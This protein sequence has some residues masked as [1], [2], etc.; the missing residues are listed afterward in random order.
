MNDQDVR[1]LLLYTAELWPHYDLPTTPER[2]QLRVDV[3]LEHLS[4]LPFDPV[5]ATL[6]SC[7]GEQFPPTVGALRA[8]ALELTGARL[9]PEPDQAVAEIFSAVARVGYHTPPEWSHPAI[10]EAVEAF[11]GWL[12]V[13]CSSNPEALRAHLLRLYTGAASRH[14]GRETLAPVFVEMLAGLLP[15]LP[16]SAPIRASQEG[17]ALPSPSPTTAPE[18]VTAGFE[19]IRQAITDAKTNPEP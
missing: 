9:A 6:A 12:E 14:R 5:R 15:A 4:D 3:W 7:A 11:G 17:S 18:V 19:R 1:R 2:L 13:C 16:E 8:R 10:G